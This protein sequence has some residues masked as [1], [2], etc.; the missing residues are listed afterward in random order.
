LPLPPAPPARHLLPLRRHRARSC[1]RQPA[2]QAVSSM[3]D[4]MAD[5]GAPLV[6]EAEL[7]AVRAAAR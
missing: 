2:T 6:E 7:L 3:D 4:E 1:V 5:G